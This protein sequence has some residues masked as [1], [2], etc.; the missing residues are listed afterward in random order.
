MAS[1]KQSPRQKMINMM[2]LVL[3][4]LLALNVSK[5]IL[6]SFHLMETSF[7]SSLKSID[8]KNALIEQ[9]FQQSMSENK[10]RT[11]EWYN[12]AIEVRRISRDFNTQITQLK[13]TI[14]LAAGGRKSLDPDDDPE[15]LPELQM[16]DNMERH[17]NFFEKGSGKRGQGEVLQNLINDTREKMLEQLNHPDLLRNRPDVI[18]NLR[19]QT[20]LRADDPPSK[21]TSR[22][23]WYGTYLVHSPLAGVTALLTK[24]QNDAKNLESDILNI[25][26]S[27]ISAATIKF[28]EVRSQVITNKSYIMIGDNFEA[29]VVLMALNTTSSP[30][31]FLEDGTKVPVEGGIGKLTIPARSA[32]VN[33]VR[34]YVVVDDPSADGGKRKDSFEY[35][36]QSAPPTATISATA[37]NVLYVGLDNPIS[38]SVPGYPAEA[39]SVTMS[40]Q[41]PLKKGKGVGEYLAVVK[42]VSGNRTTITASVRLPDGTSRTMGSQEYRIR[43]VPS[44]EPTYGNLTSGAH[45]KGALT[46]QT[47]LNASLGAGFAFEG[48]KFT[49][50]RYAALLVP[51]TGQPRMVNVSGNSLANVNQVVGAARAGDKL[52]VSQ[53]EVNGPGGKRTLTASLVIDIK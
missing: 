50:T 23:T 12:R 10:Q 53:V 11:E 28:D 49:V 42:P 37:M 30:E 41:A 52:I 4:A 13:D 22:A 51:R 16:P 20:A 21:G 19:R 44:P 33:T 2:Y 43:Q 18:D 36:W 29:D 24:I 26:A 14:V 1:G 45:P 47:T 38:V 32:G 17:A 40:G 7:L 35:E 31:I 9:G 46:R 5:E 8:E 25:L 15:S 6:K 27:Q 48:V 3:L 34:G 39:V